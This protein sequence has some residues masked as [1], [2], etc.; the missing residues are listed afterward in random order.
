MSAKCAVITGASRGIGLAIALRLGKAGYC[1]IVAARHESEFEQ[2]MEQISVTGAACAAVTAD[3]AEPEQAEE[4][5]AAAI[6]RFD[7]VDVLVNNAGCAPLAPIDE[8]STADFERV[9]AVNMAAI[10]HTTRAVWP[11]LKRQ[12]GGVIVNV[13]SV[14][15][16]DP[17]PG[18][19]V[20]GASKAWVNLFTQA[21]AAEGKPHG[22]RVFAVA[23]GAVETQMM[24]TAFP[25]FP[26]DKTLTPDDV[27]GVIESLCE[28]RMAR[29]SGQTMFVR[30]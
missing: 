13:S 26:A 29:T 12:G 24:R 16:V 17:F 15:S 27:A 8:F 23:P 30:K 3:V 10:F 21:T 14:A 11:V 7:R 5:I 6:E 4:I 22:I 9:A 25:D 18:F 2:A 19:A 1:V 20:Y 28:D